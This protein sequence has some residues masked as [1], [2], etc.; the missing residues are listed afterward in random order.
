MELL[1]W[2][3]HEEA[4][5]RAEECGA[6]EEIAQA[7]HEDY[8][9]TADRPRGRLDKSSGVV[10]KLRDLGWKS[11]RVWAPSDLP[12]QANDQFDGWK[13]FT[14]VD[15]TSFGVA[16]EIEWSWNRVYFDFLKFWRGATGGQI[17]LGIEVLRGASAFHYA[18][19]HQ[20]RLYAALIPTVPIVF[21]ALDSEDLL[22]S[23]YEAPPREYAPF[24]MPEA[25]TRDRGE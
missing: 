3:T 12:R 20:Y 9:A 1:T 21:C 5:R 17:S 2:A 13:C 6:L 8:E 23:D 18:I 25:A 22:D 14:E 15:G 10:A 4:R 11:G 19:E 16:V 24:P 7:L